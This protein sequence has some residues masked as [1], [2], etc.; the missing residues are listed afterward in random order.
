VLDIHTFVRWDSGPD[1][2]SPVNVLTL[3]GLHA[4][5]ISLGWVYRLIIVFLVF[6]VSACICD[7]DNGSSDLR[8]NAPSASLEEGI[9]SNPAYPSRTK[10]STPSQICVESMS[11]AVVPIDWG[12]FTNGWPSDPISERW[13]SILLN[14]NQYALTTWYTQ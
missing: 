13:K 8:D 14:A 4:V 5:D 9:L 2:L 12:L 6:S 1:K 10:G 11:S 7:S 3:R